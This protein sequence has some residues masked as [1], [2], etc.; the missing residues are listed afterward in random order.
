MCYNGPDG[1]GRGHALEIGSGDGKAKSE[2]VLEE[3]HA[4]LAEN[5][6]RKGDI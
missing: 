3:H 5:G 6:F 1:R 2:E 4:S